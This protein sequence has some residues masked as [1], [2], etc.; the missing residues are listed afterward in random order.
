[1]RAIFLCCAIVMLAACSSA[2]REKDAAQA[3][4]K[5]ID[6]RL[7]DKVYVV[8]PQV[9]AGSAKELSKDSLQLEAPIIFNRR[10]N[11]E[12]TQTVD[13]RVRLDAGA[14]PAVIFL[15]FNWS[16]EDLKKSGATPQG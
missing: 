13:C 12:Y 2:S 5:E 4:M 10:S 1:M 9:L 7:A 16:V 15:Q 6:S 3:C 11:E 8:D 14:P